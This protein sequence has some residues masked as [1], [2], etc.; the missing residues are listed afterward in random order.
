YQDGPGLL[1]SD[2]PLVAET[3]AKPHEKWHGDCV[4]FFNGTEWTPPNGVTSID[5]AVA[6][7]KTFQDAQRP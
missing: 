4:G 1:V 5:D 2:P 7:I 6:A 3:Q